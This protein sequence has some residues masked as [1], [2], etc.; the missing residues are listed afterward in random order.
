MALLLDKQ[1]IALQSDG[2]GKCMCFIHLVVNWD[3]IYFS[4][5]CVDVKKNTIQTADFFTL[6][7]FSRLVVCYKQYKF[8]WKA[9]RET[10]V[11]WTHCMDL[12]HDEL[13]SVVGESRQ[14]QVKLALI[15]AFFFYI[16]SKKMRSVW[17]TT[18]LTEVL[19][20]ESTW[21]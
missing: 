12:L 5:F 17:T 15:A 1:A 9:Q 18:F 11:K 7:F 13:L 4:F 8:R 6:I 10:Y 14:I 3:S 20:L 2:L 19:F 16:L 21:E